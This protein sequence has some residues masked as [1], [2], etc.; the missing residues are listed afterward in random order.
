MERAQLREAELSHP[1]VDQLSS[2]DALSD[3]LPEAAV[4]ALDRW[5]A[6]EGRISV[7]VHSLTMQSA[8]LSV[9]ASSR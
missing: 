7:R 5:G 6:V 3:C 4:I 9:A 1:S 2:A 8:A